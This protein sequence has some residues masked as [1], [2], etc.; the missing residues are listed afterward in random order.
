MKATL[1]CSVF[2]NVFAVLVQRSGTNAVQL[3]ACQRR[4]EHVARV[5]GAFG[6]ASTHH[7]MQFIDKHNGLAFVLREFFEHGFQA[8]FELAAEFGARQQRGHVQTQH[9][10]AFERIRHLTGNDALGQA[11][12]NRGFTHAGLTN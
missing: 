12:N 2:F 8:F 4:L 1:Q 5:H 7:G 9:A 3:A 6:L 10:F 11:F